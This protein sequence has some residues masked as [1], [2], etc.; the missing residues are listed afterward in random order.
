MVHTANTIRINLNSALTRL[1]TLGDTLLSA[2]LSGRTH[3]YSFCFFK[4]S[5]FLQYVTNIHNDADTIHNSGASA[6]FEHYFLL[7]R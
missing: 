6:L 7:S 1:F 3:P 4:Q 2:D 5:M